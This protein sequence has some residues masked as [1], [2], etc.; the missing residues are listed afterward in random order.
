[1]IIKFVLTLFLLSSALESIAFD[2]ELDEWVSTETTDQGR[3]GLNSLRF[4][5]RAQCALDSKKAATSIFVMIDSVSAGKAMY[6]LSKIWQANTSAEVK[7]GIEKYRYTITELIRI[8]S[9]KL[10]RGEL[11]LLKANIKEYKGTHLYDD[12]NDCQ[13]GNCYRLNSYIKRVWSQ[14]KSHNIRENLLQESDFLKLNHDQIRHND[15]TTGCYF[16]KRFSAL[17][18]H[19]Q[20]VS[21]NIKTAETIAEAVH[22]ST[23]LMINC[24][25][26]HNQENLKV[27][28]YQF[29]ILNVFDKDWDKF[30]FDFWS[31]VKTYLTWSFRYSEQANSLAYPYHK[32]FRNIALEENILFIPNGCKNIIESKCDAKTLN[33]NSMRQF[34]Q[35]SKQGLLA[36]DFSSQIPDGVEQ[37]LLNKPIVDINN[38]ILNL[39]KARD[40]NQWAGSFR[41][42]FTKSRGLLKLKFINAINKLK[43]I[44][45]HLPL[46][47]MSAQL[48]HSKL[49]SQSYDVVKNEI[50]Y[51]CSE[52]KVATDKK[53]SFLQDEIDLLAQASN[54]D[55]YSKTLGGEEIQSYV[56]YFKELTQEV[57]SFC[58]QITADDYWYNMKS[59]EREGFTSWYKE[60]TL[61]KHQPFKTNIIRKLA[62]EVKPLLTYKFDNEKR[63]KQSEIICV[64]AANCTRIVLESIFD[65][66]SSMRYADSLLPPS[67]IQAPNIANPYSERMSCQIYDPY[68]KKRRAVYQFFYDIARAATFGFLPSPVYI[69][70]EVKD[71]QVVSMK[72]LMND[73]KIS[74]APEVDGYKF[75]HSLIADLGGLF[76]IPCAI[77]ISGTSINPVRYYRFN[78]VSVGKCSQTRVN[79]LVVS[80]S[81]NMSEYSY[82]RS[83]CVAC[84]INLETVVGSAASINPITRSAYILAR[85]TWNL[86]KGLTDPFDIPKRWT[87]NASDTYDSYRKYGQVNKYCLR[88][89]L[90]GKTCL[91]NKCEG[92][93]ARNVSK[94]LKGEILAS[95]IPK[96]RGNGFIKLSSCERKIEVKLSGN[97]KRICQ[98]IS[99]I[100]EE[101]FIIPLEC[102]IRRER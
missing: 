5:N 91:A 17:Q 29:D 2:G 43:A 61:D 36:T 1:M 18:G 97:R 21:P 48:K 92:A 101:D 60:V 41:S 74:F 9:G 49:L 14:S 73:G 88:E 62:K 38:D 50:Y 70:T 51:M 63:V 57:T 58:D 35:L 80:S 55:G 6:R 65:L 10:L 94:F 31:S 67:E 98:N 54:L 42:K 22:N 25:D 8:I 90:K 32:M 53:L 72:T 102:Q 28:N 93:V 85:G 45:T 13:K 34:T 27:A 19:L 87:L 69:S 30:G 37:D 11:P 40:A 39:S 76:G 100:R 52:Y 75:K 83:K 79:N 89:L 66:F 64:E 16:I 20:T 77:A 81:T 47:E 56:S 82:D 86:F 26:I 99:N 12:F 44:K 68:Q 78:G 24:S 23:N 4:T 7:L 95:K 84:A 15:A 33:V 3:L 46:S 59:V 96:K 71:K